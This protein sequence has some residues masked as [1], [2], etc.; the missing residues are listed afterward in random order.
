MAKITVPLIKTSLLG[1]DKLSRLMEVIAYDIYD[2]TPL[3]DSYLR[4]Y[5]RRDSGP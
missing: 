1:G 3:S 2:I 4:S 5:L